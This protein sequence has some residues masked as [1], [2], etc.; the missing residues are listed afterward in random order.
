[1][2]KIHDVAIFV[3]S[4]DKESRWSGKPA[5]IMSVA[6]RPLGA[7][8]AKH[9]LHQSMLFLDVPVLQLAEA[10][11][12]SAAEPCNAQDALTR[13]STRAFFSKSMRA[14]AAWIGRNGAAA[15]RPA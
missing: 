6:L 7:F 8:G 5:A 2:S 9:H 3:G 10:H 15:S 1:M 4:L 12:G 11:M 13:D 14:C